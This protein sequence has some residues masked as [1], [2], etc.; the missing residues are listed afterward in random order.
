MKW[1][2]GGVWGGLPPQES[3]L[4]VPCPP[5]G[6]GG[7]RPPGNSVTRALP[8]WGGEAPPYLCLAPRG[9]S[10]GLRPLRNLRYLCFAP[11][12]TMPCPRALPPIYAYDHKFFRNFFVQFFLEFVRPICF[13][14]FSAELFSNVRFFVICL[15]KTRG[16]ESRRQF[17]ATRT[18]WGVP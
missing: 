7:L 3:P 6:S 1:C 14:I 15:T 13:R 2:R 12:A 8:L 4:P 16:G 11:A 10:G 17:L 9:G 5:G 18:A